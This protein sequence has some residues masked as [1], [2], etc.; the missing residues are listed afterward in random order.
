[1]AIPSPLRRSQPFPYTTL[2]RSH[3]SGIHHA[4]PFLSSAPQISPIHYGRPYTPLS[5]CGL[6][7]GLLSDYCVQNS[8]EAP[9]HPSRYLPPWRSEEHT[10]ELQSR[11]DLVCRLLL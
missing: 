4:L 2:F 7:S 3:V 1:S 8:E 11:F 5:P 10:S 6:R 9:Y